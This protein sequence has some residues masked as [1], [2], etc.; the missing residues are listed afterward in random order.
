MENL[1]KTIFPEECIFCQKEGKSFCDRCLVECSLL[2]Y[3]VCVICHEKS[4]GGFTH[5]LCA[6]SFVPTAIFSPFLYKDRVRECIARSKYAA[7]EFA[8]LK[9]LTHYG[10]SFYAQTNP[11]LDGFTVV[12]VPISWGRYKSRGFNQVDIISRI[13][14]QKF[15][16]KFE[17]QLLT[18]EKETQPQSGQLKNQRIKNVADAFAV[19]PYKSASNKKIL[20][21][22]DICTT[23]A[24]LCECS[25]ALYDAGALEVKC[26]TIAR[27][28]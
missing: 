11:M 17:D 13:L 19:L 3:G 16:L 23:G 26:F 1:F 20:L 14:A 6:S 4:Y 9:N 25:K 15:G 8:A 5:A 22:D 27:V 2:T 10:A 28:L 12:S 7:M 24:T 21:V 18:R